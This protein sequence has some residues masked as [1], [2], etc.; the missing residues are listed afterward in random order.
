M[1]KL[2]LLFVFLT[3]FSLQ[4]QDTASVEY[5]FTV[6]DQFNNSQE[7]IIGKDPFGSDGLDPEF[8]EVVVP[9]VPAGQF[10][11]RLILPTDSTLTLL[12][13]IRFGCFWADGNMH[14]LD[15]N[16]Q[17][18][19]NQLFV[20][21]EWNQISPFFLIAVSFLD[22][23]TGNQI[24]YFDYGSD[25]SFF[26]I[27]QNLDKLDIFAYYNGT[28]SV[29]QYLVIT[30]NGGDTLYVGQNYNI[31]FWLWGA[32]GIGIYF[33]SNGG[34]NWE[35]IAGVPALPT[36]YQWTVP[37]VVF[38]SCLIM[39][40]DYP[41]VYDVSNN[42]FSIVEVTPVELLSFSSSLV[43]DD[44]TLNWITATEINN[45]GFQVERSVIST[46]GRNLN[47]EFISFV[48]GNG[49]TT[50]TKTYSYKDENLSAGK[51]QYRLKQIDF[52]GTFEYSNIIEA[53]VL[54][55]S[56][57]ILEQ[58]YP[59]PFNPVTRIQFAIGSKQFVSLKIFNALGEEAASLVN[60]EKSAGFYKI[61]FNASH[62]SSGIYYYKIIAGDFV[63]TR[64][65]ILIK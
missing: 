29:P 32:P 35:L 52:D 37:N 3:L 38:D 40:G 6:T 31:N 46:E 44:V 45:S 1:K 57:F 12:K 19:S 62:L 22:P 24:Q 15:L 53:E 55:L 26:I 41:C 17:T 36:Y 50:E 34:N 63:Q 42:F 18:G 58:N 13:D 51:Y 47:W 11:A 64:K 30:P 7:L 20:D 10:G 60:E 49:T 9:Q 8:G 2:V 28:L 65:M 33:S 5:T 56:E 23:Y 16:Y 4:A 14:N 21:W 43:D 39:V 59:N 25:S 61:D 54:S 27:P 48:N